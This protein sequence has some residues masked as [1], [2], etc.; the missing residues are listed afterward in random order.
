MAKKKTWFSLIKRFF[1]S[2]PQSRREKD[3]R[4]RWVCRLLKIKELA[5]LTA[6]SP[7]RERLPCQ[8]AEQSTSS[9][10][11]IV[12][13]D[14]SEVRQIPS[15]GQSAHQHKESQ[16]YSESQSHADVLRLPQQYTRASEIL[17]AIKIQAAFRGY[18]ARKALRALKGVVKLQALIRGWAVRQQA[19]NTLKC[20]QSIVNIQSEVFSKRRERVKEL[21]SQDCKSQEFSEKDIKVDLNSQKRWD[22]STLTK[23]ELKALLLTKREA[24]IKRERVREYYLNHRR[25]AET[26]R[27]K[28]YGRR[29]YWLEQWVDSQLAKSDNQ[30]NLDRTL[31]ANSRNKDE[32]GGRLRNFQK[33]FQADMSESPAYVPKRSYHHRKQRS[34]GD[35]NSFVGSPST[36]AYMASTESAKAKTRSMSSPRLRPLSFDVCSEITSPYKHKLSPISSINSELTSNS[37]IGNHMGFSQRSPRLKGSPGPIKSTMSM[38][39]IRLRGVHHQN[40]TNIAPTDGACTM[41][42]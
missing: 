3:K 26:E 42:K 27:D 11:V 33:Q 28:V 6:P 14:T 10:P 4:R 19:I 24:S 21:H 15:N 37:W 39:D 25:S 18:L 8:L 36:P 31:S 40:G 41:G 12:T 29:R 16:E 2:E 1:I 17:V 13:T 34:I 7:P 5:P 38:K 35:E 23:E 32:I 20:L 22:D 30:G 9:L